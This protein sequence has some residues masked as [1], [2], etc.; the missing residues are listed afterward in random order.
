MEYSFHL[1]NKLAAD[2]AAMA[3]QRLLALDLQKKQTKGGKNELP[4]SNQKPRAPVVVCVGS[5]L[6]IGDSLGPIV[7]SMLKYKTQGLNLFIYGTLTAPIT[8][9]EI[10]YV[11]RF[12][13]ETHADSQIIAVDAAVGEKGDVGLMRLLDKPLSPGVGAGKRLG[14]VG[15]ISVMG[16]VAEKSLANYGLLNTT[17]LNLVYSMAEIISTALSTLLWNLG[18][19]CA[20]NA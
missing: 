14:E 7:G 11:R 15:D 12:L 4:P 9:K 1:Y 17:R 18:A 3:L 6:A 13:R 5:D 20:E 8:A 19:N 2:G 16:I 10:K